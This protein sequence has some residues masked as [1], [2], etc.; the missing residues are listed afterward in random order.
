[1]AA[2]EQKHISRAGSNDKRSIIST[3]CESLDDKILPF[4]LIYKGKMQRS[5]PT[6]DFPDGFCLS[7]N[8]KHWSNEKETVRL[9]E[10]VLMLN[11]KKFKEEKGLPNDQRS[12]LIWD[13]FK[14]QST[15]NVSDVLSKQGIESVMVPKNMTHLLQPL[16]LTTNASLKKI[17]QRAFSKYFSSSIMEA[18][19]EDP[20]RDVTTKKGDLRL[21]F[22][23][24]LHVNVMKE[25][26]QFFESLNGKEV[27]L[28]GWSSKDNGIPS[29]KPE[30][31]EN[32]LNLNTFS[33]R[34]TNEAV[35][36]YLVFKFFARKPCLITTQIKRSRV[37]IRVNYYR[38][39][40]SRASIRVNFFTFTNL[41]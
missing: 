35:D 21:S 41:V 37:S 15:V 12:L 4:Q 33:Y 17:E 20:T 39:K 30:K 25:A 13:A 26:Y 38:L 24:P 28:N 6:V 9:I 19:K 2:K 36:K 8:E 14:A 5:L 31:N 16:D 29:A 34:K 11:I 18:L 7:Y 3:V 10:Q 1:M 32:S 23:K 40:C 27:I 22:L